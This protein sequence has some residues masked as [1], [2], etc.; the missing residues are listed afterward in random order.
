M[1]NRLRHRGNR[2]LNGQI[3][4][5]CSRM[6][7]VGIGPMHRW[8]G[9]PGADSL[10]TLQRGIQSRLRP[11]SRERNGFD[12]SPFSNIVNLSGNDLDLDHEIVSGSSSWNAHRL[13]A[14][15]RAASR[16][17]RQRPGNRADCGPGRRTRASDPGCG[18]F[19]PALSQKPTPGLSGRDMPRHELPVARFGRSGE[20]TPS[21]RA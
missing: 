3:R 4:H 12:Q 5:G 9:G 7:S 17:I 18:Q 16:W 6:L 15:G 8:T 14:A 13:D 10:I 21:A 19:L 1:M 11:P 20:A 2:A